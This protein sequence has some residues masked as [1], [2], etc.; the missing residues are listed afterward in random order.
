MHI[1]QFIIGMFVFL[2]AAGVQSVQA[3]QGMWPLYDLDKLPFDGMKAQGLMLDKAQI[4]DPQGKG[5]SNA[6][7]NLS[8]GTASFPFGGRAPGDQSSRGLRRH[9]EAKHAGA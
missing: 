2:A 1:R 6:V 4:Y 3:E 5:L 7:I 9:P 8:G